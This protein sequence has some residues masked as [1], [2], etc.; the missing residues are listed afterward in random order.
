M[1]ELVEEKLNQQVEEE[2]MSLDALKQLFAEKIA[3]YKEGVLNEFAKRKAGYKPAEMVEGLTESEQ[4]IAKKLIELQNEKGFFGRKDML[5][6]DFYKVQ[7]VA[8][9]YGITIK[10]AVGKLIKNE[11]YLSPGE[12]EIQNLCNLITDVR[13]VYEKHYDALGKFPV[14]ALSKDSRS[15]LANKKIPIG[16]ADKLRVLFDEYMPEFSELTVVDRSYIAV[17]RKKYEFN[18]V[19]EQ[20]MAEEIRAKFTDENGNISKIFL[21]FNADYLKRVLAILKENNITFEEFAVKHDLHFEKCMSLEPVPAV[22]QMIEA[23]KKTYGTCQGITKNDPYLRSK[24][25]FIED[26]QRVYNLSDILDEHGVK[27]D[28]QQNYQEQTAYDIFGKM[29]NLE[30]RLLEMF[31]NGIIPTNFSTDYAQEY[32]EVL[33]LSKRVGYKSPTEFLAA[34]GFVREKGAKGRMFAHKLILSEKDLFKYGF[35]DLEFDS[36]QELVSK[37]N[38]EIL[39]VVGNLATYR[40]HYIKDH[41]MGASKAI[42]DEKQFV[43]QSGE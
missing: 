21:D 24:I 25:D 7:N 2:K 19:I 38:I 6:S 18:E 5:A 11:R 15:Y 42:H 40:D 13:G 34:Y 43:Q 3:P 22:I 36:E 1:A 37:F 31:P 10:E 17:P 23:Y 4:E 29:V 39:P 26:V 33:D 14:N 28:V 41:L 27:N 9:K 35:F 32:A 30:A 8:V 16:L 12:V 20:Q